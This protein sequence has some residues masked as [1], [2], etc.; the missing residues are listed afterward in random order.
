MQ[1]ARNVAIILALAFVVAV[2]PGGGEG[3]DVVFAILSMAFLT[4]IAWAAYRFHQ[5]REMT[6]LGMTDGQR[7]LIYG[8]IGAIALLL[9]GAEEFDFGGGFV[10]W[11]A[12]LAGAIAVAVITWRNATTYS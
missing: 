8:A 10:L 7:G 9:V 2:V 11:I 1:T 12:L 3:A 5:E 6:L 4:V